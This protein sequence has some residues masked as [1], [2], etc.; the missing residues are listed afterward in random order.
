M[1]SMNENN[2]INPHTGEFI[3][4]LESQK[5]GASSESCQELNQRIAVVERE[6]KRR[7][8]RK[9]KPAHELNK[10]RVCLNEAE[11]RRVRA[12]VGDRETGE[13]LREL[14]LSALPPEN[15]E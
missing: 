4:L 3:A 1:K 7:A 2:R 8:G 10:Y 11:N 15:A 12:F 13:V 14:I 6:V 9:P 5:E